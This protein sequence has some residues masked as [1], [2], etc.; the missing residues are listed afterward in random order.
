MKKLILFFATLA[1]LVRLTTAGN[2]PSKL[3][4]HT[5]GAGKIYN[6]GGFVLSNQNNAL[7]IYDI[8]TNTWSFGEPIPEPNGL[9][10]H[11]IAYWNGKIY[12]AGGYNGSGSVDTLRIYDV[13]SN[14]WTTGPSLPQALYLPGFGIINGKLYIAS[15]N[16]G[17]G[18]LDTLYI[19]DIA[20][21]T[22]TT[23]AT[24]PTPVT[25]AGSAVYH[26]KLYLFGGGVVPFPTLTTATQIYDPVTDTWS[27]GPDMNVA[28]VWFYGG[29]GDDIGIIAPGGDNPPNFPT[30]DNEQ[31]V[32]DN[33]VI[34][35]PMPYAAKG[36]FAVSDGTYVYIGGG[37]GDG[38]FYRDLNRYDPVADT[39][40]SLA[41]S[42]DDHAISQA[43]IVIAG[44]PTPT[45]TPTSTPTPTPTST[46]T[47]TSTPTPTPS[48]THTPRTTPTPRM[49]PTARPRPTPVPR[50]TP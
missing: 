22:W 19:Y 7:R 8:T 18:W 40:T 47:P 13:A 33:W 12:V 4:T 44:T 3:F 43:V 37:Y 34:K 42:L 21:N 25:G 41:P 32:T 1:I 11:A 36:A 24:I 16:S 46:I 27:S 39:Y 17:S 23:G 38:I 29:A 5:P 2:T 45:P 35:S 28:R 14:T 49:E 31:L 30:D 50:P 6:V 20:S 48:P 9:A 26:D 15:G 10:M